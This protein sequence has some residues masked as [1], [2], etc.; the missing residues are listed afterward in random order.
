MGGFS[1]PVFY[2]ET[3]SC[4]R[5]FRKRLTAGVKDSYFFQITVAA[6]AG[7]FLLLSAG[8]CGCRVRKG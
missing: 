6:C 8:F 5:Q 1:H 3:F 7:S 4:F 2:P